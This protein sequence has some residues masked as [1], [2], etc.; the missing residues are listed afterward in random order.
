VGQSPPTTSY[1]KTRQRV[2]GDLQQS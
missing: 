1:N 2:Q